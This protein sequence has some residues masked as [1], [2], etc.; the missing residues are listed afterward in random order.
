MP[1]LVLAWPDKIGDSNQIAPCVMFQQGGAPSRICDG[2][3]PVANERN[4]GVAKDRFQAHRI[5]YLDEPVCNVVF[6]A[7]LV[8]VAVAD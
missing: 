2:R 3:D 1:K 6:V 8:A 7:G 4:C 5:N